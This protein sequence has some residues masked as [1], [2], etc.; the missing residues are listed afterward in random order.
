[1]ANMLKD[2]EPLTVEITLGGEK[3]YLR[4]NLNARRYLEEFLDYDGLMEKDTTDWTAEEVIH[5]LRAGLIDCFYNE[6]EEAIETR[7]FEKIKPSM[8]YIGRH[9]T[10]ESLI[11]LASQILEAIILSM[12]ISSGDTENFTQ[13]A[14]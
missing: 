7:E 4:Y 11:A 2:L 12:P 10:Q 9:L 6:N 5:I 13:A 3:M 1:M 8:A 14:E